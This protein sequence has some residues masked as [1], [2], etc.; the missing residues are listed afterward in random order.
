MGAAW[1]NYVQVVGRD[2]RVKEEAR[3]LYEEYVSQ[4]SEG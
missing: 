4:G 2:R 3:G 1:S